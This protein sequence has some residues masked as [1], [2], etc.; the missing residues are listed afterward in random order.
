M[1]RLFAN[2]LCKGIVESVTENPSFVELDTDSVKVLAHPLRSRLVGTLRLHGPSTATALAK[3]LDTNSGATSYHLRQLEKAGLVRDTGEGDAKSRIWAASADLT[4][5]TPSDF[6]DDEDASTALGWLSR[7]WL[8]HFTTKF[9][10]WLDVQSTWPAA[11][12]DA[13]GMNDDMVLV[14]DEQ[15]VSMHREIDEVVKRYKRAGAGN[16][17]A[18]RVAAYLCFYPLDMDKAPRQ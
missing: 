17:L 3:L 6:D 7:D 14:T 15:L 9:E 12:R 11:W 13:T 16:P 2:E 5:V 4:H 18:K 1:P 8:R 10:R